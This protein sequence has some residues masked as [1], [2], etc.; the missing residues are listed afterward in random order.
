MLFHRILSDSTLLKLINNSCLE[1]N[2]IAGFDLDLQK[3]HQ[4]ILEQH[5]S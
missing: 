5:N 2:F 3:G 1:R 4:K